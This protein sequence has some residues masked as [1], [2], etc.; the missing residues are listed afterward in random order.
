M[1][2]TKI[3]MILIAA[4]LMLFFVSCTGSPPIEEEDFSV[5]LLEDDYLLRDETLIF[6]HIDDDPETSPIPQTPIDGGVITMAMHMPFTLNPLLNED[7]SVA[8]ILRLIYEPLIMLDEQHRPVS[9][10]LSSFELS[11]DG[12]V[13]TLILHDNIHWEDGTRITAYDIIFSF[14]TIQASR[15][16]SIYRH[17]LDNISSYYVMGDDRTVSIVYSRPTNYSFAYRLNFPI[18]PRHHHNVTGRNIPSSDVNMSPLGNG[19]FRIVNHRP[20]QELVLLPNNRSLRP[21]ANIG[22]ITVL[23]VP[24][25]ETK[26][27]AF[28]ERVI[29]VIAT[30]VATWGR[31]R[32]TNTPV[33]T[34]YVSNHY[35]F[36]GFNFTNLALTDVLVRRAIAHA[37]N[38]DEIISSIYINQALRAHTPINPA[39]WF[40]APSSIAYNHNT[41]LARRMLEEAGFSHFSSRGFVGSAHGGIVTEL[42]LRILVN[43][44]NPERV[45]IANI[46]SDS[47]RTLQIY[48]EVIVLDFDEYTAALERGDFDLFIGGINMPVYS[49]ISFM[50]SS[51]S[52]P[53]QGGL[54]YFRYSSIIMD[55]LINQVTNSLTEEDFAQNI[56][57]LQ[58]FFSYELPVISLVYRKSA[59]LTSNRISGEKHPTISNTFNDVHLWFVDR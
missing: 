15:Q 34:P 3:P 52:I 49:D 38:V 55:S 39:A 9:H 30:D 29:D 58:E 16:N 5:L 10:L 45:S 24:D 21:R 44:E 13:A 56:I 48:T 7:P 33:I 43:S 26:M 54:N 22:R 18:I 31:H 41:A 25:F 42:Q 51:S 2:F 11:E 46:L 37:I 20:M 32:S 28:N 59:L 50:F 53:Q 8:E 1:K 23:I 57:Q 35:E 4:A 47:L 27:H 12:L 14:E 40:F 6:H 19:A 17:V 36:I